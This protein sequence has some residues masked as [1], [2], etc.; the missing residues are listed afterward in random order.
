MPRETAVKAL[1][2]I[3]NC[4]S[5]DEPFSIEYQVR[6][7]E[8]LSDKALARNI[9]ATTLR[10]NGEINAIIKILCKQGKQQGIVLALLRAGIAQLLFTDIAE[11]A[12]INESVKLA[13]KINPRLG[14]FVNGV[15]RNS[16]RKKVE[17]L[18]EIDRVKVSIPKWIYNA[19]VNKYGK[20]TTY[21]ALEAS[22][23]PA[24]IDVT[25]KNPQDMEK[26]VDLLEGVALPSNRSVRV[27]S[28]NVYNMPEYEDGTWWIQ[29]F[30][31]TLPVNIMEKVIK[32]YYPNI[33]NKDISVADICCAPGG[34]TM[35]LASLGFDVVGFDNSE[36]RLDIMNENLQRT[37]TEAKTV[38]CDV[39]IHQPK[40]KFDV[41]LLDAPC[42]ATGTIRRHPESLLTKKNL[43]MEI[44]VARQYKLLKYALKHYLKPG[45]ILLFCTCS[46][47]PEEAEYIQKRFTGSMLGKIINL[48]QPAYCDEEYLTKYYT[49]EGGF[50]TLPHMI[51]GGMDA[52]GGFIVQKHGNLQ[53][54]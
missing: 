39:F 8:N 35:Q 10:H 54:K 40:E 38:C 43:D 3:Y 41:V 4:L 34:K 18:A 52:F 16:Q 12:V 5:Q 50:R 20:E 22:L 26:Y 25:L 11:Y 1:Q 32:E 45:G 9:I 42:S 28:T 31:A 21:K 48:N 14:G 7:I 27:K 29:D 51:D 2:H 13:K 47:L 33:Q 46:I 15:L 17:L 24:S 36:Y 6:N 53:K 49:P 37:K 30:S 23:Q 44:M 19:C